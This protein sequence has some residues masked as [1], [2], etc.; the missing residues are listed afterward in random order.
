MYTCHSPPWRL[1]FFLDETA[2]F[3]FAKQRNKFTKRF[4]ILYIA[5]SRNKQDKNISQNS[6]TMK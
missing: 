5:V 4:V 1:E 6:D 3:C 2:Y